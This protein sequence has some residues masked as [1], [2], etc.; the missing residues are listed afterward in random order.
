MRPERLAML[1]GAY[2]DVLREHAFF[3]DIFGII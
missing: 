3:R 1:M 2:D